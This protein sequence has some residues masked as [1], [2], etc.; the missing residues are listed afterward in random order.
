[1]VRND[2]SCRKPG[3]TGRRAPAKRIGTVV[4]T[5]RSN[6]EIGR[7]VASVFTTVGSTRVSMGPAISVSVRGAQSLPASA[8]TAVAT[9]AGDA[10]LAHRDQVGLGPEHLEPVDEV[11]D[12]AVEVEVAVGEA[13]VA[14][15]VPVGDPDVLL[16]EERLHRAAQQGGEVAGER[17][18]EQ[19]L[20]CG[21]QATTVGLLGEVQQRA[22]RLHV[23]GFLAHRDVAAS[24]AHGVDD[25]NGGRSWVRPDATEQRVPGFE[26]AQR[27]WSPRGT[28]CN[29]A[30]D[31][32]LAE[33]T[34]RCRAARP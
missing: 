21:R 18:D 25:P 11:L 28:D 17:R 15:V 31:R 4:I 16:G 8:I 7:L 5:L 20:G 1:M 9:R 32:N 10:R 24:D 27:A 2:V 19:H 13:D 14:R 22:E 29:R 23:G 6:H 30:T 3:Y 33:Q 34:P 12:V 26:V